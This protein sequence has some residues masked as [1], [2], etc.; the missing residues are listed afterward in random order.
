M[1]KQKIKLNDLNV[2]SFKTNERVIMGGNYPTYYCGDN[3]G[4]YGGTV[5]NPCLSPC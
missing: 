2:K 5:N 1:K 4:W 3:S